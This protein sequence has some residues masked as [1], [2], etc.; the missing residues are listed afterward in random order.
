M[1][2]ILTFLVLMCSL[3]VNAQKHYTPADSLLELTPREA[4]S[5]FFRFS[6][7]YTNNFNFVVVADSCALTAHE[8]D[9]IDTCFVYKDDIV[10]VADISQTD[11]SQVWIKVFRDQSTMGWMTEDELLENAVPDDGISEAIYYFSHHIFLLVIV[12]VFLALIGV[13]FYKINRGYSI[14]FL[15]VLLG[16]AGVLLVVVNCYPE[17]WLEYYFHP[18]LNP[19]ILPGIMMALLTLFWLA[20]I[21]FVALVFVLSD[22]LSKTR[23]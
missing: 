18:T 13:V 14:L 16:F 6:H 19:F 3:A 2:R 10:A 5:L 1:K 20:V 7:H 17:Y 11:S 8:S 9:L 21:T 22:H 23:G 15:S 4:D 12:L